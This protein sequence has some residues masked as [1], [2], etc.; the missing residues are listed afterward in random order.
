MLESTEGC[1]HVPGGLDQSPPFPGIQS[2]SAPVAF[3]KLCQKGIFLHRPNDRS[4]TRRH[5]VGPCANIRSYM[6]ACVCEPRLG[7]AAAIL[8]SGLPS[9]SGPAAV[10]PE[11]G[12]PRLIG[13]VNPAGERLGLRPGME[14][15]TALE[16]CPALELLPPDPAGLEI[17]WEEVL[18][19]LEGI[20]AEMEAERAGE[21]F[22]DPAPL[23]AMHGSLEIL[24]AEAFRALDGRAR[25]GIGPTRLAAITSLADSP[26]RL[27]PIPSGDLQRHLDGLSVGVLRGRVGSESMFEV[28][29]RVGV[30]TLG[31][32]RELDPGAVADRFGSEG[33]EAL[34]VASGVEPA[35]KT[36]RQSEPIEVRLDLEA[37][38]GGDRLPAAIELVTGMMASRLEA[39][40]L[41]ARALR[42][43][44]TL[45][46]GGSLGRDLVPRAPTRS[47]ST[48]ALLARGKFELLP[49]LA[50]SLVLKAPEVTRELPGQENLFEDPS[51]GRRRRLAEAARQVGVAVNGQALLRVIET[52]PDSR[53]P[54][55]RVV[56]VPLVEVE[57]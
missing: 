46:T 34:R 1:P 39:A 23:V 43:E 36:R 13:E 44:V 42:L 25:L 12:G 16:A 33:L 56:M 47:A 11:D 3:T 52:D 8:A 31:R 14:V 27:E 15:G 55:R 9:P 24:V 54:E 20:G 45:E 32:F 57:Q 49:S 35:L 21:A 38:N 4:A 48:I 53:L 6:V 22:F 18:A 17:V 7:L 19:R 28:L 41:F 37:L 5:D 40:G 10:A 2:G 51:V 26:E 50:S 29:D 30:R